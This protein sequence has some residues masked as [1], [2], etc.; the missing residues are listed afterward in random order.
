MDAFDSFVLKKV[1]AF[2]HTFSNSL[3][4]GHHGERTP[5][6]FS[7]EV[8]ASVLLKPILLP[9]DGLSPIECHRNTLKRWRVDATRGEGG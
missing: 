6:W 4:I 5:T 2:L 3:W 9:P 1:L 7:L 8:R